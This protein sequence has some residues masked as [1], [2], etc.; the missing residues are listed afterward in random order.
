MVVYD[1]DGVLDA[2]LGLPQG[3]EAN[4]RLV[5]AV[6]AWTGPGPTP[7]L[8]PRDYQQ[9]ALQL[10]GHGRTVAA[11][12]RRLCDGLP[13]RAEPRTWPKWCWRRP[14]A[15][16]LSHSCER[17]GVRPM[18]ATPGPGH[19]SLL[20]CSARPC[21]QLRQRAGLSRG[22]FSDSSPNVTVSL[23]SVIVGWRC[24]VRWV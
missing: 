23:L 24:C 16:W 22:A 21:H 20:P 15:G 19:R 4:A 12:L 13:P 1:P 17:H 14:S 8:Q 5:Q 6:I 2:E 11:D 9:I 7:V 3:R 10:T 18:M